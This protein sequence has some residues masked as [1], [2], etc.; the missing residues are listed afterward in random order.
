MTELVDKLLKSRSCLYKN[1]YYLRIRLVFSNALF[2][3]SGSKGI[4]VAALVST[5]PL[6]IMFG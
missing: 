3:L 6:G 4:L 1:Y 2:T 5:G